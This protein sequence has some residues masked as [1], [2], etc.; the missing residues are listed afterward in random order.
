MKPE[1]IQE[2][3]KSVNY[4]RLVVESSDTSTILG[5]GEEKWSEQLRSLSDEQHEALVARIEG[6]QARVAVKAVVKG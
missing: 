2:F 1:Q 6:W 5:P 4:A 3:L